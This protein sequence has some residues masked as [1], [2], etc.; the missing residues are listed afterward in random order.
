MVHQFPEFVLQ[1]MGIAS[2]SSIFLIIVACHVIETVPV[3]LYP[4]PANS[5]M[6]WFSGTTVLMSTE[7]A[8]FMY[9]L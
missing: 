9:L 7:S 8:S 3:M 2:S 1:N 4:E 6:L 5:R